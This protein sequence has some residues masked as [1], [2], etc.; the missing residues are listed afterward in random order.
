MADELKVVVSADASRLN[1]EMAKA[2]NSLQKFK[3][4]SAQAQQSLMNLGRV[5][6]D[7]PFGFIGIANNIDPL[8][9]SFTRLKNESGGVGGALKSLASSLIGPQGIA[10]AFSAVVSAITFYTMSSR[11]AADETEK[12]NKKIDEAVEAQKKYDESIRSATNS[13]FSQKEQL[14]DLKKTLTDTSNAYNNLSASVLRN[15]FANLL[16]NQKEG[17]LKQILEKQLKIAEEEFKKK[18]PFN[19]VREFNPDFFSKDKTKK[20]LAELNADLVN[21]NK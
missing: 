17:L 9:Q 12:V 2:T 14:I 11:G 15:A 13:T 6:Q 19:S 20:D 18:N 4:G 8:I 21:L 3:A 7:A 1:T 16:A 10:L 5:V